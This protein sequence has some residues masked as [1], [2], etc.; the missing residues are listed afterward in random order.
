M[1]K[2]DWHSLI[3]WLSNG[4]LVI[5][6][7]IGA[8]SLISAYRLSHT[9]PAGVCPY[10]SYRSWMYVAVALSLAALVLSFFE[11]PGKHKK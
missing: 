8:T 4:M 3:K 10:T 5:A 7:L 6:L 1:K 9:L 11:G 2:H